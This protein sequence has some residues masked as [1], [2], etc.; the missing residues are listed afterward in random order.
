MI[1]AFAESD[2]DAY[3]ALATDEERN[4][5]W[6]YDYKLDLGEEQANAAHFARLLAED[7]G[8]GV[9]YSRKISDRDGGFVG[10]AVIYN[11]RLD[12]S[13]ELGL[14]ISSERA[15]KGYGREAYRAVADEALRLLPALHARCFKCNEQSKKMILAAGFIL[16]RE[17]DEMYYFKR[18]RA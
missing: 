3:A 17:D 1:D 5:Y 6:G 11:F 9:C 10:E 16:V 13:A 8:R 7:E 15:G 12:G 4:R 2:M 18:D 14:R